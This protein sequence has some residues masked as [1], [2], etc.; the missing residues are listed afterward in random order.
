MKYYNGVY[1]DNSGELLDIIRYEGDDARLHWEY[2]SKPYSW[3]GGIYRKHIKARDVPRLTRTLFGIKPYE[4][5]YGHI[6][7]CESAAR[8]SDYAYATTPTIITHG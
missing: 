5:F 3:S 8:Y 6:C 7:F 2:E 4:R 1:R